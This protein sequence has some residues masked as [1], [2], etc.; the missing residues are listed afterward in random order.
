MLGLLRIGAVARS[1]AG[2]GSDQPE[3]LRSG[4]TD[5][6]RQQLL[7]QVFAASSAQLDQLGRGD[8]LGLLMADISRT[9]FSL[10][11]AMRLLQASVALGI[12]MA[13]VLLWAV[14]S[15]LLASWPP[16]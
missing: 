13:G 15:L 12:Y 4:F 5:Q 9:V 3:R 8:L 14:G 6:L 16:R 7:H 10:D 1:A 2:S 11:Q